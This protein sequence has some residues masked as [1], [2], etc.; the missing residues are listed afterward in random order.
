[1]SKMSHD[2]LKER[3]IVIKFSVKL[4]KTGEEIMFMLNNV[5]CEV[6]MNKSP[7]YDWI[8]RFGD[9]WEGV[10]D[11]LGC[12]KHN[13]TRT[14]SNVER[15]KQL[16]HSHRRLSIRDVA[17]EL[18]INCETVCLIVKEEFCLQ[19]LCAKLVPKNLT[20]EQKKHLVDV[21]RD[22]LEA[23]ES[24]N[25]LKCVITCDESWLFE[26]NPETKCQSTQ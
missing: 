14:P 2:I 3:R 4:G 10:N 26:Y 8:Q 19:N 22:W 24:E 25:I 17:D 20:E 21:S 9:G 12:G 5:Y 16:L 7:V 1:M 6:T 18:S 11:C 15:V 13:E 23:I